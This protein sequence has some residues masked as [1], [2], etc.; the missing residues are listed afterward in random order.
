M[1]LVCKTCG[2][3][4]YDTPEGK[5][6]MASHLD[7]HF[8]RN[9]RLKERTKQA[10]SRGWFLDAKAWIA[11]SASDV[12]DGQVPAFTKNP[13]ESFATSV[14]Q[15]NLA[16]GGDDPNSGGEALGIGS[17]DDAALEDAKAFTVIVTAELENAKC[18]ICQEEL[19]TFWDEE[20]EE[21]VY[22]HAI[23]DGNEVRLY[24]NRDVSVYRWSRRFT[25]KRAG[26]QRIR[27]PETCTNTVLFFM[28]LYVP[29]P[30]T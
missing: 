3:R 8:R 30:R 29:S 19:K 13:F 9:R 17:T 10:S 28:I 26:M 27:R 22:R 24:P 16:S 21:W 12:A 15:E 6:A 2:K 14:S 20:E 7:W 25:I 1:A 11:T 18:H 23:R 4:F 5:E